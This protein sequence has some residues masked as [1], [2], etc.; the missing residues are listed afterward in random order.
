MI[1][2]DVAA[3]VKRTP[4]TVEKDFF[5]GYKVIESV[6]RSDGVFGYLFVIK[7]LYCYSNQA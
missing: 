7:N 4:Y 2:V 3:N 5:F 6:F 1:I